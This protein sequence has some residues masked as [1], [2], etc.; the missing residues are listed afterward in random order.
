MMGVAALVAWLLTAVGG[1][2]MLGTWIARGGPRQARTG[3][4]SLPTPMVVGHFLLAAAGLVVWIVYLAVDDTALAWTAFVLLLPVAL[5]GFGM[6]RRWIPVY[7]REPV[8]AGSGVGLGARPS[9]DD[10]PAERHFPVPV[11][12]GHGLLAAITLLLVL[13]TALGVDD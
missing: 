11:V 3:A 5:L 7:R 2:V 10:I 13:L 8:G 6:L 9:P 4:T 12:V 1:L